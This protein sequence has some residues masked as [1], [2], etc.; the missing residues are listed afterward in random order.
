[1][2]RNA[3]RATSGAAPG[4]LAR[5]NH[6]SAS[7]VRPAS[8]ARRPSSSAHSP[9][10]SRAAST[11]AGSRPRRSTVSNAGTA[12][13]QSCARAATSPY[14]YSRESAVRSSTAVAIAGGRSARASAR[15]PCSAA[16]TATARA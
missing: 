10:P 1:M 13:A 12:T 6:S 8:S 15:R 5:R 16:S 11:T 3:A 9:M 14:T 4:A 7:A 2:P